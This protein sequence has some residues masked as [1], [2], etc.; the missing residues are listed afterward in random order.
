VR[1]GFATRV[2]VFADPPDAEDLEFTR[3]GVPYYDAA[4]VSIQ[5]LK[6]LGVE[7]TEQIGRAVTGTD[8][9]SSELPRWAKERGFRVIILVCTRDHSRRLRRALQR[10]MT[11]PKRRSSCSP[12][13]IHSS[14]PTDGG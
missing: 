6:A 9:E 13:P 3:R 10:E 14:I 11:A 5:Q 2:A 1:R 4:S 7:S 8:D 12:P